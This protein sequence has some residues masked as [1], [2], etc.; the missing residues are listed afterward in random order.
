[1]LLIY[2]HARNCPPRALCPPPHRSLLASLTPNKHF[3]LPVSPTPA[4]CPN[5]FLEGTNHRHTHHAPDLHPRPQMPSYRS[6]PAHQHTA[7][8]SATNRGLLCVVGAYS[9]RC[10]QYNT[11]TREIHCRVPGTRPSDTQ[12]PH[13]AG[14]WGALPPGPEVV[15]VWT[16]IVHS[17][18]R[19]SPA[20][21]CLPSF[22]G[23]GLIHRSNPHGGSRQ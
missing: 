5:C 14:S 23:G 1:M 11:R 9:S 22:C 18:R 6:P 8:I 12:D 17:L 2:T 19:G 3:S 15:A 21:A 4:T 10:E 20:R 7:H 16:W 13:S